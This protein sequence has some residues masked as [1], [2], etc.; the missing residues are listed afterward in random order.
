MKIL[1]PVDGSDAS[2]HAVAHALAL[3]RDGLRA[4]FV[5]LNV[6]PPAT[7]YEVV[8]AHDPD[9]LRE[10]RGAAGADLIAPAEA[11]LGEHGVEWESEVAGGDPAH[12][13]VEAIE[14]YGC[15]AVVMGARGIGDARAAL[16]GSVSHAVLNA[17]P[18]PVTV[19]RL[20]DVDADTASAADQA[21]AADE[22]GELDARDRPGPA[23]RADDGVV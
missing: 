21:E 10:V 6:Q 7:L 11:L 12:G 23:T 4:E 8:T 13:I 18:V 5:L 9:V 3:V 17:S 20:P 19:V 1:L 16:F 2:L 22:R 15:D 14:R